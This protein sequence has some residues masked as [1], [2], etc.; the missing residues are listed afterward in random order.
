[1]K[2]IPAFRGLLKPARYKV[3]WGGRGAAKS[4]TMAMMLVLFADTVNLRIL[5]VREFQS[6]IADSVY[7]LLCDKIE[8][9]G[10]SHRYYITQSTIINRVTGSEFIFKGLKRSIQEIK[11]TEGVDICWVEE[12]QSVSKESWEILIP[13]IRKEG[14]QIWVSF[15]TGEE[16]DPT[17]QRFVVNTPPNSIVQKVN[18]YDNPHLPETLRQEME[19]LK[20]CDYEAYRHVWE[21]EPR[22]ISDAV[23]MKGKYRID[24]FDTPEDAR[25]YHGVDW[26]FSQDPTVAVRMFESGDGKTLYIDREAYGVGIDLDDLPAM[27]DKHIPTLKGWPSFAD[28]AR[29]ETISHMKKRGYVRMRPCDKWKGSVEDGIA[30]LRGNYMC[31]IIHPS[32]IHVAEEMKL[33]SYKTDDKTGEVL[34][35]IVD[36]HNHTIDAIRYGLGNRIKPKK[37]TFMT[38]GM[39]R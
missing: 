5:C 17:Y 11:S 26:G 28:N 12:G 21:G 24:T 2:L 39:R 32:C 20:L 18:F 37:S 31:I 15:N 10:L 33:Y 29:P 23:I 27:F 1:M 19:Y 8:L 4:H 3:Y 6:S 35:V 30:F 36:K 9:A 38:A 7:R 22:T 14:S 13:T 16:S 25:F 34:P